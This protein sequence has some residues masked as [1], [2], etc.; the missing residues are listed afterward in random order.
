MTAVSIAAYNFTAMHATQLVSA[1]FRIFWTTMVVVLVWIV[2]L[3][4]GYEPFIA[5]P[6]TIQAVGFGMLVLGDATYN[7]FVVWCE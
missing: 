2:C 7:R 4:V 1:T 3:V 6:F 5:V